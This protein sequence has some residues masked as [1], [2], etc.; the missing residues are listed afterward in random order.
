MLWCSFSL[1]SA[2][3]VSYT[4]SM[5]LFLMIRRPPRSTHSFPTR[6]SSDLRTCAGAVPRADAAFD[7]M[8]PA[9][10][11]ESDELYLLGPGGENVKV[12]DGLM[13]I[14]DRKSTR[15]NSSH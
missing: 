10:V 9:S 2:L 6:R 1:I 7:A 14:K 13:D 11:E 4:V 3:V 8:A 12:R 15:L 5:L